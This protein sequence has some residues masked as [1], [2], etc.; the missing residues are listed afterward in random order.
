[1]NVFFQD[2]LQ[3]LK[4][5]ATEFSLANPALAPLLEGQLADPDVERLLESI[6]FQNAML[7]RKLDLDF[8]ELVNRLTQLI[9]PHYLRP[10]PAST[11]VAFTQTDPDGVIEQVPAGTQ[12]AS[13]PVDGTACIFT[14]TRGVEVQPLEL[15][16]VQIVR[17]SGRGG[18]IRLSLEL[19][20]GALKRWKPEKLRFF[21]HD[22][23]ASACELFLLLSSQVTR[24]LIT[25]ATGGAAL[26]LP[27]EYLRAAG[28]AETEALL[29]YPSHAFPG[30]RLLQEYLTAPDGFLFFEL[31][32]WEHWRYRGEGTR[33]S[34]SFELSAGSASPPR[35]RRDSF[36]L[37]AVP[38]VNLFRHQADPVS[39]DHRAERH[40]VRPAGANP[41]HYQL[42]SVD[43]V[44]AFRRGT[45]TE[46]PYLPFELFSA[47]GAGDPLYQIVQERSRSHAGLDL[48]LYVVF[49]GQI[50]PAESETLSIDLTCSN[51]S[52]PD[53]LHIGDIRF[54]LSQLPE[55][56]SVCNI[57]SITSGILPPL[58]PELLRKL[59]T[60]VVLNQLRLESVKHLRSLL[61]LYVFPD[62]HS[63]AQ[64]TANLK[65]IAGIESISIA[66]AEQLV[67]GI[68]MRGREICL[69]VRQDH[70]AGAGDLYLFG[71]VLDR[72]LGGYASLNSFTR[73]I[74]NES[75]RGGSFQWPTR[76]GNQL[77]T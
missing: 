12:I 60:H 44:T 72:F 41:A 16:D 1:M 14:T 18:Q 59:T 29:P 71:C 17:Q 11:V 64:V 2:Q 52:L 34:L 74:I 7:R 27:P 4:E 23:H 73:L 9:L 62:D 22:D 58:G 43:C 31:S 77:L 38:A 53:S 24:I 69:R 13:A 30:Y 50:P 33:F 67:D 75:M 63:G 66:P 39:I 15:T 20:G 54:P 70:F 36:I 26:V 46:R 68:I 32:G 48:Y 28:C 51:G 3:L 57:T 10:I 55:S 61:E 76:L 8:P 42:L 19:R 49:S 6:G 40:L 45:M 25:P 35:I 56:V 5:L 37:N 21:L 65:R 47:D